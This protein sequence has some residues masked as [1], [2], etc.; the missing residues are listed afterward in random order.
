MGVQRKAEVGDSH[1]VLTCWMAWCLYC[2]AAQRDELQ[3]SL[4]H[5]GAL[6]QLVLMA[7]LQRQCHQD[8]LRCW[9][10]WLK[11]VA[12]KHRAAG[13]E[14][15]L[16]LSGKRFQ[17]LP[18]E[19]CLQG[20]LFCTLCFACWAREAAHACALFGARATK[21]QAN[22]AKLFQTPSPRSVLSDASKI[23]VRL[24]SVGRTS[25]PMDCV[26]VSSLS[27]MSQSTPKSALEMLAAKAAAR[28]ASGYPQAA[29]V[30]AADSGEL[31]PQCGDLS[32]SATK[33]S[34]ASHP[35]CEAT[36]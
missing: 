8:G 4:W 11:F 36:S 10:A 24:P 6:A 13:L 22:V 9:T 19:E 18:S 7:G 1:Q 34:D 35:P 20:S 25:T 3:E 26:S 30:R 31:R 27:A 21:L 28:G 16:L 2:M 5:K 17:H 33:S 14:S 12:R 15:S 23:D 29:I 32:I